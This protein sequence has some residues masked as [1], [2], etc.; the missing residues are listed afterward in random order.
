MPRE[1]QLL[2]NFP[3]PFN[4]STN[5]RY[6]LPTRSQVRLIIYDIL[7]Q[8]VADLVNGEQDG[9]WNQVSW[10]ANVPSGL[11][12]YRLEA[13]SVSDPSNRFVDVK[14]MVLLR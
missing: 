12:F 14:K 1:T 3:N 2:A 10:N 5:I 7:G 13:V 8:I 9:G 6:G 11:Y 4:P